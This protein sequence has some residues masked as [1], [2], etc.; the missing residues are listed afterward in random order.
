LVRKSVI[1]SAVGAVVAGGMHWM[2]FDLMASLVVAMFVMVVVATMVIHRSPNDTSD[3][4]HDNRSGDR[5]S[6]RPS[7]DSP[8]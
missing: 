5:I 1:F 3:V 7:V 8:D 4:S 2:G 6:T